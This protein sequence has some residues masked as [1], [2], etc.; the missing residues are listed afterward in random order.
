MIFLGIQGVKVKI[1][2]IALYFMQA[3]K[4]QMSF[5]NFNDIGLIVTFFNFLLN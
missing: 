3:G 1:A 4:K 2:T 5:T